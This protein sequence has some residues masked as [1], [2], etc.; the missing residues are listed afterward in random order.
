MNNLPK[1]LLVFLLVSFVTTSAQEPQEILI[2]GDMHQLPGI[3]KRAYKP[4][5]K[6]ILK[7]EP[8][9][10]MAEY[11]KTGDTA[12][13]GQWNAKFKEAYLKAKTAFSPDKEEIR[14]LEQT[15]NTKLDSLQFRTLQAYYLSI[16]DQANHRMYR[17]FARH[18]VAK[19]FKPYGNQNP[20]LTFQLMRKLELKKVYGVDSHKGYQGY[21]TAWQRA[22]KSGTKEGKKAFKKAMRKD[23]WG[24]IFAGVSGS[25]GRYVNKPETLDKYFRINSL[26]YEGFSGE[27]YDIQLKKWDDRNV[28]MAKNILDVLKNNANVK[29]SVLIVG[30]GHAKAVSEELKRLSPNL[31]VIMY[32]NLKNHIK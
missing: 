9:L 23:S 4:M 10:I 16:G 27:D 5:V 11:S 6:K 26:R 8:E 13:M 19:K 32:H 29:R 22:L 14:I 24:N 17:Y 20:D 28:N 30:A 31:K 2:V 15:P 25:L 7:Y 1:L 21:W 12:A 3:V 18:G